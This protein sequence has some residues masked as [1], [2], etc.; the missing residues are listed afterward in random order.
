MIDPAMMRYAK[1]SHAFADTASTWNP[2]N[3]PSSLEVM[4]SNT[5]PANIC[6]PELMPFADGRSS[7]L[8]MADATDQLTA[9]TSNASA[10]SGLTAESPKFTDGFTRTTTPPT[11]S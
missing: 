3:S 8:L 9:P 4:V 1:Q 7:L 10:P 5:P 11:P 2:R 6:A